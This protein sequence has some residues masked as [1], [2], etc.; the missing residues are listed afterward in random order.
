MGDNMR[1]ALQN[2]GPAS[3]PSSARLLSLYTFRGVVMLLMVSEGMGLIEVARRFPES[4]IWQ[5]LARQA[6]HVR[7]QGCS[8][9]DLIMPAFLLIVGVAVPYSIA[10]AVVGLRSNMRIF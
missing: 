4:R 1:S 5:A 10:H 8:L 6:D 3:D 9:W 2:A 7:W